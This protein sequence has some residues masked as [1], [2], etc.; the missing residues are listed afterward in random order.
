[1][2]VKIPDCDCSYCKPITLE[3]MRFVVCPSCH[4]KRCP[5]AQ[6]HGFKCTN[7]NEL[8]QVGEPEE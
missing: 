8:N 5:K 3:N 6:Y 2:K 1:M 7:N 4:N